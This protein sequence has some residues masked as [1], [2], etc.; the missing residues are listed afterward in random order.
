MIITFNEEDNIGRTLAKLD[1][2]RRIVVIDSGST[3]GT[4]E[5]LRCHPQVDVFQREF[6]DFAAQCNFGLSQVRSDW[7]LSLD[8]DYVLSD[9][10]VDELT[11]VQLSADLA[12]YSAGFVY[13]VFGRPLRGTLYPPRVVLFRRA[14]GRYVNEGHAHRLRL[15]G[16]AGALSGSILHDDRKPLARWLSSQQRYAALQAAYLLATPR[17]SLRRTDR[18]RLAGWPA[19]LLVFAYTLL[20]K[21]LL[22]DGWAGWYYVLQRVFA[23]TLLSLELL[24]R[25]LRPKRSRRPGQG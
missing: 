11:T 20:V 7:V 19:P 22:F 3:D 18:I 5:I 23:E 10:F 15:E 9:Q 17:A 6:D 2:A 12:G 13:C 24:D 21:G 1:W 16:R 25:R 8:A 14:A 4:L